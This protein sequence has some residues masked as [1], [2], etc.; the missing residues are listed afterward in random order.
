MP[1][2]RSTGRWR[3]LRP[4][5]WTPSL[6]A[7]LVVFLLLG[8]VIVTWTFSRQQDQ[9]DQATAQTDKAVGVAADAAQKADDLSSQLIG[10]CRGQGGAKLAQ[11]LTDARTSDG[12][13]LCGVATD[14]QAS[15]VVSNPRA[16]IA[17]P[18]GTPGSPGSPGSP[19]IAGAPGSPGVAGTPGIAG[20]QGGQGDRGLPG[21]AGTN[22]V[23]GRNGVDG[24]PGAKGDKGDK[25]DPGAKGDRGD[26][27]PMGPA[28][29][30]TT[31]TETAPAPPPQTTTETAPAPPPQTVT[32]TAPGVI[33]P[34]LGP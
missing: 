19:G 31:V 27:G 25:G 7:A 23:N 15:P 9:T 22:G 24:S 21:V 6:T 3:R 18:P 20:S 28:G 32:Q 5:R 11:L 1:G 4:P 30:V 16:V 13:P 33:P 34:L 2:H 12:R 10:L 26:T 17:G 29:P 14:I 8:A